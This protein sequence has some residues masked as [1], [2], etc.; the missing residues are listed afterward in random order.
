MKARKKAKQKIPEN[1]SEMRLPKL[2]YTDPVQRLERL[3]SITVQLLELSIECVGTI[4]PTAAWLV[5]HAKDEVTVNT[6]G[7]R[8]ERPY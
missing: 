1:R 5:T 7:T 4:D 2:P 8:D 6:W 3:L